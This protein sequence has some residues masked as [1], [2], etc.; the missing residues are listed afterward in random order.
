VKSHPNA[1]EQSR[2][3]EASRTRTG[4]VKGPLSLEEKDYPVLGF[5]SEFVCREAPDGSRIVES[6]P[7]VAL[8]SLMQA[9]AM[10]ESPL[11]ERCCS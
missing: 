1:R 7:E 11:R 8:A 10:R 2:A 9:T 5:C 6:T 3:P 4:R